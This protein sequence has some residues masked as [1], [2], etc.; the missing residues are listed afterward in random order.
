MLHRLR[1]KT[2]LQN[3][4]TASAC[5]NLESNSTSNSVNGDY[6]L[7]ILEKKKAVKNGVHLSL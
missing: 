5:H 3:S 4:C 1:P 7:G 6:F 2:V